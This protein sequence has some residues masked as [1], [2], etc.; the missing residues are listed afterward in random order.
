MYS[1]GG[2]LDFV[3]QDFKNG[4]ILVLSFNFFLL[5]ISTVMIAAA[6]NI[7]ND[8]FD[9]RADRINRPERT[10]VMKHIKRR[11]AIVF[12]WVLNFLAFGIAIYLGLKLNTFWYVFIHL[13]SI[14]FL[15]FYSMQL[16]RTLVIGNVVIALLTA[17]V[18][19]LV[20]I[21]YQDFFRTTILDKAHPFSLNNYKF[22]PIYLSLGLG[23]FAFLLNFTREIIKDMEDIKG[24][25]VLKARTIPIVYGLKKSRNIAILFLLITMTL[26]V[27][28]VWFWEAG[29][30]NGFALLP[31]VLSAIS[32]LITLVILLKPINNKNLKSANL[33]IKLT[34]IFGMILPLFWVLQMM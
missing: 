33:S 3:Y 6:G 16:K 9:V 14:N 30:I 25:L 27:P 5:V 32:A 20:G 29:Y 23:L 31:L 11:W 2:Y 8:Y 24:D 12:H 26:T 10:I 4:N 15:W 34:I 1:I 13:L 17:L 18:P 22:F 19:V 21:Y 28:I 7:I